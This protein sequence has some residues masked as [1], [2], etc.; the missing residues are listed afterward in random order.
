M[1]ENF[2]K[3]KI[4]F[5]NLKKLKLK[6]LLPVPILKPYPTPGWPKVHPTSGEN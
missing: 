1:Y 6:I 2:K 4:F 3:I 5:S